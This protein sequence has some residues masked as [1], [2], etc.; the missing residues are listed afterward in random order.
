VISVVL[1]VVLGVG[2]DGERWEVAGWHGF[3]KGVG[4][5]VFFH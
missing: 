4:G 3:V 1:G 2:R 5:F